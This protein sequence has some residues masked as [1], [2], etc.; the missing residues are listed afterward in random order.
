[1]IIERLTKGRGILAQQLYVLFQEDDRVPKPSCPSLGHTE[2]ML[3]RDDF[4]VIV[5]IEHGRVVGGLTAYEIPMYKEDLREMFLFEIAVHAEWR[6][7]G[8]GTLLVE[9]IK[10]VCVERDIPK[11][12]VLTSSKNQAALSLYSRTGGVP[13]IDGVGFSY[14]LSPSEKTGEKKGVEAKC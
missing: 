14:R 12:F 10:R 7:Q 6:H 1:M 8:V 2:K 3:E 9:A 11:M 4:H 13:D 5:A